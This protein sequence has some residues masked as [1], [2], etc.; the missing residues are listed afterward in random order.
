VLDLL[1]VSSGKETERTT[2]STVTI[3]GV[4]LRPGF[5]IREG[6]DTDS[7]ES[8]LSLHLTDLLLYGPEPE[9]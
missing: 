1:I 3:Q 4:I 7:L 8:L 2:T 5:E 6:P 9:G